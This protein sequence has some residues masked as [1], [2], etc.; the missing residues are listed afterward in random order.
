MAASTK[1]GSMRPSQIRIQTFIIIG[2]FVSLVIL[3]YNYWNVSNANRALSRS[4]DSLRSEKVTLQI[5]NQNCES[6]R[7]NAKRQ[8]ELLDQRIHELTKKLSIAEFDGRNKQEQLGQL[9]RDF[10]QTKETL[11]KTINQLN[12]DLVS[13]RL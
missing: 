7:G 9:S 13:S 11:Q 10:D 6:N 2:L 5:Q 12:D 3:T 4:K 1:S 8:G